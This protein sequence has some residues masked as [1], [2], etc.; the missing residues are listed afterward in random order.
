MGGCTDAVIRTCLDGL[1]CCGLRDTHDADDAGRGRP[2]HGAGWGRL[3]VD[4]L[5]DTYPTSNVTLYNAGVSALGNTPEPYLSCLFN[6][7]PPV[8][9]LVTLDFHVNGYNRVEVPEPALEHLIRRL[10]RHEGHPVVML[11]PAFDWCIPPPWHVPTARDPSWASHWP[12]VCKPRPEMPSYALSLYT[13]FPGVGSTWEDAQ[14]KVGIYYSLPE[15]S[16]RNALFTWLASNT[17]ALN[18]TWNLGARGMPGDLGDGVH[19]GPPLQHLWADLL[20]LVQGRH[21]APRQLRGRR[22]C[23]AGAAPRLAEGVPHDGRLLLRLFRR[24]PEFE[25]R[26]ACR[27]PV[28]HLPAAGAGPQVGLRWQRHRVCRAG[29]AQHDAAGQP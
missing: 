6:M 22:H 26:H 20:I 1:P 29:G 11:T 23:A 15:V 14:H 21:P 5:R 2:E 4:W 16:M 8:F 24:P 13:P 12:G 17:T 18:E 7:L 19:P 28:G 9:H 27:L 10:L 3:F 25:R